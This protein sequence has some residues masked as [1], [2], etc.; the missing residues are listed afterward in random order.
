[1]EMEL[2]LRNA[3]LPSPAPVVLGLFEA[4]ESGG[5]EDIARIVEADPALTVRLLHLANSAFYGPPP[6]T[7]VRDAIVR[8]GTMDVAALGLASEVMRIFRGIPKGRFSMTVFWQHS[9][10]TACYSEA[11]APS[12][13]QRQSAPVWLCGLIHDV[14]KLL[15][16]RNAPTE[17]AEVLDRVGK[18]GVLLDVERDMLGFTHAQAG[19]ELL[20]AW[21]LPPVLV[22]CTARHHEP[23]VALD[24]PWAIVAAANDLANEDGDLA[25]LEGVTPESMQRVETEARQRH[26]DFC[27]LFAEDL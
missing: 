1:M 26:A 19:A 18:D 23:Y 12:A 6:V 25:G 5:A 15:L 10:W 21:R 11:L 9:L 7:T 8:V 4:L 13:S 2:L 14:G 22:E 17:Y 16:A 24:T 3:R 20:K 27:Q